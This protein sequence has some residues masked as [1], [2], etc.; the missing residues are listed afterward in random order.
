M[1]IKEIYFKEFGPYRERTFTPT[2]DG[3][4]LIYGP[5][6]SGKTSLLAGLR[7]L[8][9]GKKSK[10]YGT[11][12]GHVTV[13]RKDGTYHIGRDGKVLNF[14]K[15]GGE[16]I[17]QEP[18]TLWWHGL[19]KKTYD[20]IFGVT[21]DDLQ[22]GDVLNEMEVRTRFFG[23]EG[24]EK[25]SAAV[26]EIEKASS[27]LLVASANG[28]RKINVLMEKLKQ[29]QAKI[30]ELGERQ[31]AYNKLQ[32]ELDG[33]DVTEAEL[34]ERLEEWQEYA[35]SIDLVLRAW[36]V[37]KRAEEAKSHLTRLADTQILERD[38]FMALDAEINQ[39]REHMRIWRGKEEGLVPDNFSPDSPIGIY[40]PE[41]ESLYQ[42]I[43][44][45]TQLK[46]EC[47]QGAAYLAKVKE[48]L[49][50]SRRMHTMWREN[51]DM[52]TDVNWRDGERLAGNLRSAREAY[53]NWQRRQPEDPTGGTDASIRA[54]EEKVIAKEKALV[55]VQAAYDAKEAVATE[56]ASTGTAAKQGKIGY[57]MAVLLAICAIIAFILWPAMP[58]VGGGLVV[59]ALVAGSWGWRATTKGRQS[60]A[61]VASV[62][63]SREAVLAKLCEEQGW[64]V[65]AD[66]AAMAALAESVQKLREQLAHH[67][68][69]L[70]QLH[71]FE[72]V[73]A[74][75][76]AEGKE[77]EANGTK[78]MDA[79]QRWLPK[80][81]R[82]TLTD[83]DF[84]GMKQEYDSYMEQLHEYKGYEKRLAE[85]KEALAAI[86]ERGAA[87]WE[88]LSFTNPVT[89]VELRRVYSILQAHRRNQAQWEQ[90]ESQRKNYREEYDQ[91]SRKEKDLLLQQS[92]LLQKSGIATAGEYRMKLLE[93]DRYR[94]WDTI[95]KQSVAQLDL[96]APKGESHE[97][98][99]RRLKG[100]NKNKWVE[101][102]ERCQSEIGTL[103][104]RL[105]ALYEQRGRLQEAL[106]SLGNDKA[107]TAALQ[108]QAQQEAELS[109]ALEDWAAQALTSY[110][111][112]T[113]QRRYEQERQP[114]MLARASEYIGILTDGRY[115]LDTEAA[116]DALYLLDETQDRVPPTRWSSGLA[117]QVYLAL[118]L[119]LAKVFSERVESLPIILDDI[120]VRFDEERQRAAL[121]LLAHIGKTEQVLVFTC[122]SGTYELAKSVAGIDCYA[123]TGAE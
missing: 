86:E 79:W 77:L 23:A 43:S 35:D 116:P 1:R 93:Q 61:A 62:K 12:S 109:E 104:N 53:I 73:K 72:Q 68:V 71:G 60:L 27:E 85:H 15:A 83:S 75:W 74:Q 47:E 106:A 30:G 7:F 87:L 22:G 70:A 99:Y 92:E 17:T 94:Q 57:G 56:V 78:A 49:A 48:Q 107:Q 13:T 21:L 32:Q 113:A 36:D 122:H 37:Y 24:G 6:E 44:K 102:S 119:S 98:L 11:G 112:D 51:E 65:P 118:R 58:A 69:A 31:G 20:S 52:P 50:L 45:W 110:F 100:D 46:K 10:Q 41:I 4:Q 81:A 39:C 42:E 95:Y 19:T 117:D 16:A 14:Y 67:N 55:A 3:V 91:W 2:A 59:L 89:P 63:A 64:T 97:L 82:R 90:K 54:E 123:L 84:F 34:R 103:Q 18:A 101:E 120:L 66:G 5:N 114:K 80:A 105:T 28:K 121:K 33:T 8:L 26:Q 96:L 88:K 9:F 38:A 25:M 111:L 108:E 76:L 115:T 40:A 29:I